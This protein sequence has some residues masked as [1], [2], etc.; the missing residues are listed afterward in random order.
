[1]IS[2]DIWTITMA[3]L[4]IM[5]GAV[6]E[7]TVEVGEVLVLGQGAASHN[8]GEGITGV[9]PTSCSIHLHFEHSIE[10]LL[11]FPIPRRPSKCTIVSS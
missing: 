4:T 2:T 7:V 10:F 8:V 11:I 5:D 9:L 1:M 3:S 6:L